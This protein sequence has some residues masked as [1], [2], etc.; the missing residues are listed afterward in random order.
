MG[1][2]KAAACV[3]AHNIAHQQREGVVWLWRHS[4]KFRGQ[5]GHR[6]ADLVHLIADRRGVHPRLVI[7]FSIIRLFAREERVKVKHRCRKPPAD[8][9]Y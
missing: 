4:L 6:I 9:E 5:A 1:E 2:E 3:G 8:C 7:R